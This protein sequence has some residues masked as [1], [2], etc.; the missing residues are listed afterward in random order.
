MLV[1]LILIIKPDTLLIS[2]VSLVGAEGF[3]GIESVL[4]RLRV[5]TQQRR[6]VGVDEEVER[7]DMV[8]VMDH[9][10]LN[11]ICINIANIEKIR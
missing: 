10:F 3:G 7:C 4:G 9:C 11:E 1:I 5:C 8:V 2:G 6:M